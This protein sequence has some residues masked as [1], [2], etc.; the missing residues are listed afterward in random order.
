M[1]NI[2]VYLRD[3]YVKKNGESS[4]YLRMYVARRKVDLATG[5]SV[6]EDQWNPNNKKIK[7]NHPDSED[8]NLIIGQCVA[9]VNRIQVR[10]NL[11]ERQLTPAQLKEEYRNTANYVDFLVWME[12][13][14][15]SRKKEL[16]PE[17]IKLH[18]TVFNSLTE[19]QKNILFADI[20]EKFL[21]KF[22]HFMRIKQSNNV[23]TRN[24]KLRVFKSYLNRAL[25]RKVIL[26][27]PFQMVPIKKGN[28]RL[29]YLTREEINEITKLY[30]QEMVMPHIRQVLKYFLFA[31]FT[32]LRISDVKKLS[33]DMIFD[34]VIHNRSKKGRR[35]SSKVVDIP[36]S[37]QARILIGSDLADYRHGLVFETY[38]DQATNRYLKDAMKL[39]NIRKNISFHVGRH[40]FATLFLE[41]TD[42]LATLQQLLGHSSITQTMIY[43]HVTE[44][45]KRDQMKKFGEALPRI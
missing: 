25:R 17:T 19:F 16:D 12:S 31:C 30:K 10:Y 28:T 26:Y 34:N 13:E 45:K 36:L 37:K 22:D 33:W 8:Y 14:I 29:V 27:N 6:M 9:R 23:T 44:K 41:E 7:K 15:N 11:M 35:T 32:G 3:D 21:E 42:D 40:T 24:K 20:D 2:I 38:S 4:I 39:C 1:S 18:F 43:A 5:V